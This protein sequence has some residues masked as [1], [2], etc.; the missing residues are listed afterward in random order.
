M[1]VKRYDVLIPGSYF[2]DVIF[3]GI[4]GFP[5]LGTELYTR[6]L[7][8]VPGGVMN[9]VVGLRRLG[10]NVGWLGAVGS[11]FFSRY[12]I[13]QAAAEGIDMSLLAHVE[14]PL[15]RVTVSLSYTEDRA[16]VTYVDPPPD[17]IAQ[18][19]AYLDDTEFRVMHFTGLLVDERLPALFDLCHARG[20][21]ISMDCQHRDDTLEQPLV[22]EIISRLDLFV[23]NATEAQRLT[24]TS[25]LQAAAE[26]LR[27]LVGQL[28]IKEGACGAH[29]WVNGA[30][31]HAP[32]LSLSPVDTTGAGDLFNAGFLAA[33][34]E[35]QEIS[36]CL[37]WGNIAGGLSTLGYGGCSTAP[38]RDEL[39]ARLV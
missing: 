3:T 18:I 22:R 30:Y 15:R 29:A 26:A 34:L 11:D 24:G 38:T 17:L 1:A 6:D 14:G 13:E 4:P 35:G 16:F 19:Y 8:V 2:C 20:A 39:T 33:Y 23:P 9:T 36:A 27:P 31:H 32:A 21:Q 12:I 5:A 37:R 25:S 28:V 7:T 10:V